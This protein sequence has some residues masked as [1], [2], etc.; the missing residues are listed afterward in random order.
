MQL[1]FS[2]APLFLS[3]VL[4]QL[5]SGGLGPLDALSGLAEG[6]SSQQIGL[7][8]SAHFLGFFLGCWWAPRLMGAVGH[9]RAFAA[10][11]VFGV[12]GLLAHMLWVEPYFWALLRILSGLCIA[13][14][15]TVIE[16]W[17]MVRITKETR[18]RLTGMYR[19]ADMGAALVS[20]LLI[21]FLTPASYASYNLLALVCCAAILPLTL[22]TAV[23]PAMPET[24]RLRPIIAWKSSPLAAV[25]VIVS[26]LS[27]ATFRMI[28]PLYGQAVG[29]DA[30]QIAWFLALFVLGGALAQIPVGW[31]ADRYDRRKVLLVVSL[32]TIASCA[33]S[34][35]IGGMSA[36]S[37]QINAFFFGIATY[38]VYSIAA[39]HAH[40][41]VT[42]DERAELSAALLFYYA[43]GAIFAPYVAAWLVTAFGPPA[44]F[45]MVAAGHIFLLAFSVG[46]MRVG[47][48]PRERT[49]YVYAP[50]TSFVIGRLLRRN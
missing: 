11:V 18:G 27:A 42:D 6:F 24:P 35:A 17:L 49:A 41:F 40:D 16:G 12:I 7:L 37:A 38:P 28:G 14:S 48:K 34:A 10:F 50:R 30:R 31:L 5:S 25:A 39:A 23:Q 13:G 32:A 3:V 45:G 1:L 44:I 47:R 26:A 19:M 21:G 9:A 15:Y 20:Q 8:G 22:S 29:L 4:L 43:I 46:R 2:L 33:A 36:A